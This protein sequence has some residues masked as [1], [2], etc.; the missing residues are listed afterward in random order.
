MKKEEMKKEEMKNTVRRKLYFYRSYLDNLYAVY[1]AGTRRKFKSPDFR[2]EKKAW[3][4]LPL[5]MVGADEEE[6]NEVFG[7]DVAEQAGF[8]EPCRLVGYFH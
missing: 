4:H 5:L 3:V 7:R 1:P 8:N 6:L 2:L